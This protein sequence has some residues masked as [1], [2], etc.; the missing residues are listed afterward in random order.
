M[1]K[2]ICCDC[3]TESEIPDES[4]K[5]MVD[6]DEIICPTCKSVNVCI[7]EYPEGLSSSST[8]EEVLEYLG[9]E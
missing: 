3:N 4:M 9:I 1:F 6:E 2:I 7:S 5:D 8:Y